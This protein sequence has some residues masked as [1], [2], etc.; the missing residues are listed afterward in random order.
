MLNTLSPVPLYHQLAEILTEKVRTGEYPAG[1]RIPS[2]HQLAAQYGIGR[3]T[4]RQATDVLVR[5]QMLA[6]KKGAGT[7]VLDRPEEVDLFSLVGTSAAFHAK[8]IS[9]SAR[10]LKKIHLRERAGG[11]PENPFKGQ[12]A[13]FLSRL[14]TVDERPVIVEDI[15]LHPVLFKGVDQLFTREI[16]LS[17]MVAEHYYMKPT[18]GK[19]NFMIGLPDRAKT[20]ALSLAAGEPILK[21]QRFIHFPQAKNAIYSELLCRTDQFVFSQKLGGFSHA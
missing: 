19:Q 10:M 4:A 21:V 6:R 14:Q 2:E 5:K 17:R 13:Y 20:V 9:V 16:S 18:G 1:S 7:F 3:P 15:W 11:S 12:S 8:G